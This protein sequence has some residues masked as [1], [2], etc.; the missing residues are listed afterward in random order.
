MQNPLTALLLSSSL[1]VASALSA[2]TDDPFPGR[3]AIPT[4]LLRANPWVTPPRSDAETSAAVESLRSKYAPFLRSL[5]EKLP[6]VPRQNLDGDWRCRFEVT[7]SYEGVR[8]K[9]PG[10]Y[11]GSADNDVN[12]QTATVPEWRWEPTR[13]P[14]QWQPWY[15]ASLILWYKKSFEAVRPAPGKRVFLCFDGVDWEA[16]VWLN[17]KPLGSH[18]GYCEPF[19][20]DVTDLLREK[21]EL[22]VR[23]LSGPAYGQP[24]S[25]W[26]IF[27]FSPA[28]KGENQ[29]YVPGHPEKSIPGFMPGGS[30]AN[31]SGYGIHR[32]V[33]LETAS[34]TVV[35]EVFARGYPS[36]QSARVIVETD[37]KTA[38]N[39]EVEIRLLPENFT[40]PEFRF[41]QNIEL[42]QGTNSHEFTIPTP[43]AQT[44][45]PSEPSLYRARVTLRDHEKT[46]AAHDALFGFRE[47]SFAASGSA[48]AEGQLLLNGQ[49]VFLRGTSVGGITNLSIVNGQSDRVLR[50]GLLLKAANF[51]ALRN[52]QHV[53]FPEVMEI[54]DRLGLLSQQEQGSGYEAKEHRQIPAHLAKV[55]A[56]MARVTFNHPGVILLSFMNESHLDM[57]EPIAT[58]LAQDPERLMTP[59]SGA[60]FGL[61]EPRYADNLIGSFHD[62]APW[63]DGVEKIW[64]A[65][66]PR[67]AGHNV[68]TDFH[69]AN[70]NPPKTFFPV[71]RPSRLNIVGEY[72]AEALD[73]YTT[74]QTYPTWWGT[75]PAVTDDK[76][77]GAIQV[78]KADLRQRFGFRGKTPR[79][80]GEYIEASQNYQADVLAE[81]SK[82]FRLS[83]KSLE[84]YYQFHFVDLSPMN[85]PKSVLSYDLKPKK[86]YFEMAQVNQPVVPLYRVVE[87]GNA[88]EFWVANDLNMAF[89]G[90]R[91][92]W[93][94]KLGEK[95][96]HGQLTGNVPALDA[97]CLGKTS[98]AELPEGPQVLDINLSL[99]DKSGRL[100]SEFRR[101]VYRSLL[102]VAEGEKTAR[103][104]AAIKAKYDK[105]H[106]Q[107]LPD[108]V[109]QEAAKDSVK[110]AT[111]KSKP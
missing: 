3:A 99:R 64:E 44:W 48:F 65:G 78:N 107:T 89:P 84:G 11:R 14:G 34:D 45:W 56:P 57:T 42:K 40:G 38:T 62:Y 75:T 102:E 16:E 85:W 22:S 79:N 72:G 17:G 53:A 5:P 92:E 18:I 21:N 12:W 25:Q 90:A 67:L 68:M 66:N 94:V 26:S 27:P 30:S 23:V 70:P 10:W 49:P 1:L 81:S 82:G 83:P 28:D 63:Y 104:R 100:I 97:V 86:G 19:R 20:F 77:W 33:F 55:S 110:E 50:I 73:N 96:L 111:P 93:S 59:I 4:D 39:A 32:S 58:V 8:P 24:I 87:Q 69:D 37:A 54:F 47:V 61:R 6:D 91:I 98:L 35:S 101:E 71:M 51:N 106:N 2:K 74:M 43:K 108:V 46:I 95:T 76:L 31:G 88:L 9:A 41:T 7:D 29:R 52:N 60:L 103:E 36:K 80:L 109:T 13:R 15:P 105:E